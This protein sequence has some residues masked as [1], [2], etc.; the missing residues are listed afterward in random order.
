MKKPLPIGVD[1]FEKLIKDGYCYIDKT[2]FIKELLD[3]KGEVNLF[4]RPRRFGKKLNL[5][6]LRYFF[7]DT[8]E[9]KK[10]EENKSLF[11][12]LKI[13]EQGEEYTEHMGAYPVIKIGRAH[14]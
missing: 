4:I 8:G 1:N 14:V 5:S 9:T 10:N 3:L 7:E 6:M 11:Q 13:M 12:G 2:M